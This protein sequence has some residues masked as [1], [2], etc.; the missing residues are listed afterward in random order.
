M[1]VLIPMLVIAIVAIIA[2][3][4]GVV[5]PPSKPI[6]LLESDDDEPKFI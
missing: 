2:D 1:K 6:N 3:L 5:K 4:C